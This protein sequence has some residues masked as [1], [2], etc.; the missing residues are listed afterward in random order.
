[1][2][3][4]QIELESVGQRIDVFLAEHL[5][6]K[7]RSAVQKL[8]SEGYVL[9]NG[10]PATKNSKLRLNDKVTVEEP[11]LKK[12]EVE[13][14][15]IPLDIVYED[16]DLLV[17]NKS[18]GMVVHPAAGNENGTLVNALL[19]HCQGTLSGIN[20]VIRP[21]IVHRID[22]DT[23][24]L[25]IVA[26]NDNAHLKLAEQ[27]EQHSFS[28]VYHA[29]VYGNIKDEQGTIKSQL[30]RHPNDRKKIAVLPSGGRHAVTH[31]RV[32]ERYGSFTYL[33]LRLETGRTHQIRVHMAS[34]G[35][36]VAGDP[37]YGPKKV[38]HF[39]NGQ[40]LHAKIIGFVHPTTGEY[41]EFN[42]GLPGVFQNF[43]DKLRKAAGLKSA[44][45]MADFPVSSNEEDSMTGTIQM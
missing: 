22:K 2:C 36:P 20:G 17:V 10:T 21:G 25:L 41:L 12:L 5:N 8:V 35:H 29:V 1:M 45:S 30:G 28:R 13:A 34:I 7:T 23:S 6:G 11:E 38:L 39:L 16:D 44:E 37:V 3:E 33:E 27:I 14:E 40:C 32:L 31:F 4:F 42:S 18:K 19:Y 43:L 24:G 26:K 9:I 15:D